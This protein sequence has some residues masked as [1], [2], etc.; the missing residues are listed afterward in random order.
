MTDMKET[1]KKYDMLTDNPGKSLLFFV[2]PMILGNLFQ[3]LYSFVDSMVVGKG[4]GDVALAA[5]GNTSSVH[6]LILGFAMG[7]TGGLGICISHS[8]GANDIEKLRKEIAMSVYICLAIGIVIT[9]G[10]LFWMRRL[11]VFLQTPEDMMTDTLV[12]FGTILAGST[13][14]IFNNFAM[15]LLR[16]VGNSKVPLASMIVSSVVNIVLD[17]I[18]ILNKGDKLFGLA[19][20]FGTGQGVAGAAIATVIGNVV[21]VVFFLIYFLRGKSILSISPGRYRVRGGIARGVITVGLPAAINSLL[22]SISNMLINVFL[23]AYGDNAVAAMGITMKA[24]M[25]V[26]MLQLGLAQGIQPLVGYCYGANNLDRMRHS[27]RFSCVCNIVLGTVITVIYFIFTRQV[28]SVFIDDPAVI[29]YGVKML[30]ALMISGP[31]IGCMFVLNFSFQ[32]MGKGTQSMI[33]SL[34]RQGLIYF[35]LLIIMN[36]TVGLDG[37]IWSQAVADLVCTAMSVVMFLLVV[38]KLRR[39]H[40][41][42]TKA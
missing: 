41:Q 32:G 37:I 23:Q 4:I 16:S 15:T 22:M 20:P 6:F 26:V 19:M 10:S 24:N 38:R 29:D 5:V 33:L 35:P 1:R 7:L 2:L 34:S 18:F 40:S 14:T 11:F 9:V 13:V 17:P 36:K 25:L 3:Q 30:R 28:V 39:Q 42:K 27:I 12:Y 21:S 31:V 8:F